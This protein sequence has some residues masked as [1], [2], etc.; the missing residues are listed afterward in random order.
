MSYRKELEK[1]RDVDEDQILGALTEE[2]IKLL[3]EELLD[4]DPDVSGFNPNCPIES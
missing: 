3:E 4:L 2:E 1:Y